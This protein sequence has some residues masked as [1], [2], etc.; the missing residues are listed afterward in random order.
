ML[1]AEARTVEP[2]RHPRVMSPVH[3]SPSPNGLLSTLSDRLRL[4]S[5][6]VL[7]ALVEEGVGFLLQGTLPSPGVT[8][9]A[10]TAMRTL[11]LA[12]IKVAAISRSPP[13]TS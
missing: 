8:A 4:A 2:G 13:V 11:S 7:D 9:Y 5:A 3:C 6:L 12:G 1:H 10:A